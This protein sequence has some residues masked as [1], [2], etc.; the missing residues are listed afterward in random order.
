MGETVQLLSRAIPFL[1]PYPAWVKVLVCLWVL[2]GVVVFVV[3][4]FMRPET[5]PSSGSEAGTPPSVQ[6]TTTVQ[7]SP[8]STV[9]QAGRD[10][11][12]HNS[13]PTQPRNTGVLVSP[14]VGV[15][16]LQIGEGGPIFRS[17]DR[18]GVLF[19]FI[20]GYSL[21]IE[22]VEGK[23]AVSTRIYDRTLK[24]VAELIRNE[25][26]VAPPPGIWDRNYSDDALEV[27]DDRGEIVLQVRMVHGRVQL[28]AVFY[29]KPDGGVAFLHEPEADHAVMIFFNRQIPVWPQDKRIKPMFKYPSERHLGELAGS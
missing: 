11:N 6:Q 1:A 13:A 21:T 9:N 19:K 24:L 3:L 2:L 7:G 26:K 18:N 23:V 12:I 22:L 29:D 27:K 5:G 14:K 20:S 25:W 10:I 17:T 28:Q 16:E 8:N 15:A 4:L